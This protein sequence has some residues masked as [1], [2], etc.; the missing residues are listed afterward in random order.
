MRVAVAQIIWASTYR[1]STLASAIQSSALRHAPPLPAEPISPISA[2]T[3]DDLLRAAT[4]PRRRNTHAF[5]A[6]DLR[7]AAR[8]RVASSPSARVAG[9]VVT[10]PVTPLPPPPTCC[11]LLRIKRHCHQPKSYPPPIG[12]TVVDTVLNLFQ[13]KIRS[14]PSPPLSISLVLLSALSKVSIGNLVLWLFQKW[15]ILVS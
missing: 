6:T 10:K 7:L 13:I 2:T 3:D 1:T 4:D 11:H 5:A 15:R 8:L 12:D 14:S 9:L